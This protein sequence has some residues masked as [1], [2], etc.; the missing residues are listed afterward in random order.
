MSKNK[1]NARNPWRV[2]AWGG[3]VDHQ[4]TTEDLARAYYQTQC[5]GWKGL[6]PSL[7]NWNGFKWNKI[8]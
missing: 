1:H 6:K 7:W 4:F 2:I 8:V 3:T 5:S